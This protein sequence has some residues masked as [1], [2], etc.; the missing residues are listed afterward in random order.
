[1]LKV[2]IFFSRKILII[3]NTHKLYRYIA[4]VNFKKKAVATCVFSEKISIRHSLSCY[5]FKCRQ[6]V[7][8]IAALQ[9]MWQLS[10][11]ITQ[12]FQIDGPDMNM[13]II[14]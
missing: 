14:S 12:A 9:S 5:S 4:L 2:S 7:D 1:M 10:E 6:S 3:I 8:F 11:L 13:I